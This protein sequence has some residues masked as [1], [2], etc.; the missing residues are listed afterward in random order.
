M[1]ILASFRGQIARSKQT[2][3]TVAQCRGNSHSLKLVL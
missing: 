1:N 3:I 2:K